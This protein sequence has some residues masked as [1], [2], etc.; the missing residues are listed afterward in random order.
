MVVKTLLV[1]EREVRLQRIDG[2]RWKHADVVGRAAVERLDLL[3]RTP[4]RGRR[5]DDLGPDRCARSARCV[6]SAAQKI[7]GR[8]IQSHHGSERPGDEMEL[9]LHDEVGGQE[10][11]GQVLGTLRR[12]TIRSAEEDV[13][14]ACRDLAKELSRLT[15]PRHHCKCV[16]GS[17]HEARQLAVDLIVHEHEGNALTMIGGTELALVVGTGH[18][19]RVRR[20]VAR[21]PAG[22][23]RQAARAEL[24]PA[25]GAVRQRTGIAARPRFEAHHLLRHHFQ[26]VRG[27]GAPTHSPT[28]KRSA[29]SRAGVLRRCDSSAQIMAIRTPLGLPVPGCR[30]TRPAKW[31]ALHGGQ[32]L[33]PAHRERLR[34][35]SIPL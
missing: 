15:A 1:V 30:A 13:T 21:F 24:A 2:G 29:P 8:F 31:S 34:P 18:E 5:C 23:E 19:H 33:N 32:Q 16:H 17:D 6:S 10:P 9:V 22:H 20:L 35:E 3:L 14:L 11:L 28:L 12:A 26:G 25:P 7:H 27:R 4:N